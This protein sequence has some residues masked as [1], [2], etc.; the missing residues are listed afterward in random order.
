MRPREGF[1]KFFELERGESCPVSPLLPPLRVIVNEITASAAATEPEGGRRGS[2]VKVLK[3]R[4]FKGEI[5]T[6]LALQTYLYVD[7]L[8][9]LVVVRRFAVSDLIVLLGL[10]TELRLL[11]RQEVRGL[12][13][14]GMVQGRRSAKWGLAVRTN[15][16]AAAGGRE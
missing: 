5:S 2:A 10:W 4:S 14:M 13:V 15:A 3:F 9:L 16:V 6:E 8:V 7:L 1:L 12:V 11:D